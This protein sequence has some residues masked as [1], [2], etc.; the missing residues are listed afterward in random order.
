[1]KD[2]VVKRQDDHS[3]QGS[4]YMIITAE[5]HCDPVHAHVCTGQ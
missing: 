4:K 2:L 5:D 3:K 1:M